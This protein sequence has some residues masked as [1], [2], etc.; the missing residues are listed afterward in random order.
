MGRLLYART[1]GP[2][3]KEE[4][5]W[6]TEIQTEAEGSGR[7]GGVTTSAALTVA[8]PEEAGVIVVNAH[9]VAKQADKD[10]MELSWLQRA[11]L[12]AIREEKEH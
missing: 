6:R 8:T 1:A 9:P 7:S 5:K 10:E 3:I 4:K 11:G 2:G 12:S